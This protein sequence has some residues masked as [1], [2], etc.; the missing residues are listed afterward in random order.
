MLTAIGIFPVYAVQK[1]AGSA[2]ELA[3]LPKIMPDKRIE[4]LRSYL[5]THNSPLVP[6]AKYFVKE[7]DR[8]GLD[9]RLVAAIA[10]T[11][12]TFGKHIPQ[13][14]Y[15]GW[16]WGIPT[17]ASSGIAFTNWK[18]AI[19]TVSVGLRYNYVDRGARTVDQMGKKYAASPAWSTHVKYFMQ[20]IMAHKPTK[21]SQLEL[22]TN[23]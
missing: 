12:S 20:K 15:N 18:H 22:D 14:S 17:G 3:V 10:G 4:T 1:E 9:W 21:P 11:E 16:G 7:A 8:L 6:E 19:T 23:L 5:A 2:G 13:A